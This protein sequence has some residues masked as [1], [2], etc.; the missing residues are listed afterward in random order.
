MHLSLFTTSVWIEI[1]NNKLGKTINETM[2]QAE[3]N[4]ETFWKYRFRSDI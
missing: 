4:N 3:I 1:R 2:N